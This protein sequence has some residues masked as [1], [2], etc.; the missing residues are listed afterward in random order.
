MKQSKVLAG[1]LAYIA[2]AAS[3]TQAELVRVFQHVHD[4]RLKG[5]DRFNTKLQS[6][7]VEKV[8]ANANTRTKNSGMKP[9][10]FSDPGVQDAATTTKKVISK[11]TRAQN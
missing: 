5:P 10:W 4:Q 9:E 3:I 1:V 6:A 7:S 11:K 2:A 8:F